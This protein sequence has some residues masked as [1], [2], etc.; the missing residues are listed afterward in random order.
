MVAFGFLPQNFWEVVGTYEL[1]FRH[2]MNAGSVV[3]TLEPYH[4]LK[5]L[6]EL[7]VL[8]GDED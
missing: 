2:S 6:F 3:G 5:N 7:N 8:K 4:V 1:F